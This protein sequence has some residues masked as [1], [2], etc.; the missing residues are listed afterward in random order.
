MEIYLVVDLGSS[1]I[2]VLYGNDSTKLPN[3]LAIEPEIIEVPAN[4]LDEYRRT[5]FSGDPTSSCFVEVN[6]KYYAVG[7]LAK[8]EFRSTTNLTL[9]KSSYAVQRILAALWVAV[10]KLE[11]GKKI[12]LF[13]T[14]L[15]P[16]GELKDKQLLKDKLTAAL[17]SFDSPS[18]R[19]QCRLK[20]FNCH[21]EGGGLSLFYQKYHSECRDR[22]LGVVML[23]H[24]NASAYIVEGG[25]SG[26]FRSSALG[27]AT[28]VKGVQQDTS[29]YAEDDLTRSVA[30]YLL[31]GLES[32]DSSPNPKYLHEL[33]LRQG[34]VD[35]KQELA[36]LIDAIGSAKKLYW[37]SIS[38][39]LDTQLSEVTDI[40]IGGGTCQMFVK[41]FRGYTWNLPKI[42]GKP[43]SRS[44]LNAGLVYP[45]GTLVPKELQD[46]YADAQCL[47]ESGLMPVV[48]EYRGRKQVQI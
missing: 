31:S 3:Y 27:F 1:L 33:L 26:R 41:E 13:L 30:R 24:R 29:G 5:N 11:G 2:K 10:A 28:I 21:P 23:G 4:Y 38:Q 8:R 25:I 39:W 47:W 37:L 16:P 19:L 6:N 48:R 43:E 22:T 42:V 45:E 7:R 14:C 46:R 18:G 40:L 35:R 12:K 44:F 32:Y 17:E 15:L 34:E 9:L 36:Q 20:Y